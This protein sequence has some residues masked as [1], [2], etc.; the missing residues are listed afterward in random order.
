MAAFFLAGATAR[1]LRGPR[2]SQ[3]ALKKAK[4]RP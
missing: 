3:V 1:I 2:L 4:R